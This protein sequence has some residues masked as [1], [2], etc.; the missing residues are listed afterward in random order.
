MTATPVVLVD[1]YNCKHVFLPLPQDLRAHRALA[2]QAKTQA[3][4]QRPVSTPSPPPPPPR[5]AQSESVPGANLRKRVH[6]DAMPTHGPFC[7]P[8]A[9]ATHVDQQTGTKPQI[10][11]PSRS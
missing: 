1:V 10:L 9:K 4:R 3:T 7:H 5:E 6:L 11:L 8:V 2:T